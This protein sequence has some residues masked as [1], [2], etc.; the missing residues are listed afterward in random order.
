MKELGLRH[1]SM[2]AGQRFWNEFRDEVD[3][4]VRARD[5]GDIDR[6]VV[7]TISEP[8]RLREMV[9]LGVDGIITDDSAGLRAT[10]SDSLDDA[11]G[12]ESAGPSV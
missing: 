5:A 10:V 11:A 3:E 9:E 12:K 4:V 6:V 1:V 7:W 8:D 2:G